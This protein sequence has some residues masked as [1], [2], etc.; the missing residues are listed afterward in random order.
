M[1]H[2]NASSGASDPAHEP[3]TCAIMLSQL[4]K[5]RDDLLIALAMMDTITS[6][7]VADCYR[8]SNARWLLSQA[9]LKGCT[10]W[11]NIFHYLLPKVGPRGALALQ[12]L[13]LA[14]LDVLANSSSHIGKWTLGAV[15]ADW[16]G[17]CKAYRVVRRKMMTCIEAEM[18]SVH[19]ILNDWR[20]HDAEAA[21]RRSI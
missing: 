4:Q 19:P 9:G 10:A 12:S 21:R 1:A 5:S 14:H 6:E 3:G 13:N 17:Y 11:G 2:L 7:P 20:A 16:P 18:R 15:E 8:V